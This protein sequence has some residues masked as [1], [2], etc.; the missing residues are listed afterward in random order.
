MTDKVEGD[1]WTPRFHPSLTFIVLFLKACY[2]KWEMWNKVN[3]INNININR[4][5]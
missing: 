5:P 2:S 3:S 1:G 4:T